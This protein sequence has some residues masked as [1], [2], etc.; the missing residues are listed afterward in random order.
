[1]GR[2]KKTTTEPETKTNGTAAPDEQQQYMFPTDR[3]RCEKEITVPADD[4]AFGG[5]AMRHAAVT[6]EIKAVAE[7]AAAEAAMHRAKLKELRQEEIQLAK[8]VSTRT[9]TRTVSCFEVRDYR[10]GQIRFE[11]DN[12]IEVAPPEPMPAEMREKTRFGEG[13][14][15]SAERVELDGEEATS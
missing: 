14:G 3:A 11:D 6:I 2:K 5:L 8:S 7:K 15:A 13:D 10:L 9:V 12:G 1:M 4:K